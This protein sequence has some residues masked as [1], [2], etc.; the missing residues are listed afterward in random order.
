V[1]VSLADN[2]LAPIRRRYLLS[3]LEIYPVVF[4]YYCTQIYSLKCL[5]I[6]SFYVNAAQILLNVNYMLTPLLHYVLLYLS[7]YL[8][9]HNILIG[10]VE[11]LIPSLK[12]N[13]AAL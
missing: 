4:C 10:F 3:L 13:S 12:K 5:Y 11:R 6:Y 8:I 9:Q 7:I 2:G 1:I